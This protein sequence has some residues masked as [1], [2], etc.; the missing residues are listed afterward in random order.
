MKES[1]PRFSGA[2]FWL[3]MLLRA[4]AHRSAVDLMVR[5]HDQPVQVLHL[6]G[7]TPKDL[8]QEVPN[9]IGGIG[10]P[11]EA[12][13]ANQLFSFSSHGVNYFIVD[14]EVQCAGC[15]SAGENLHPDHSGVLGACWGFL[16]PAC[17]GAEPIHQVTA[18]IKEPTYP[19]VA[20]YLLFHARYNT[21][22][23]WHPEQMNNIDARYG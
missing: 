9:C 15:D 14:L 16:R 4:S 23:G 2:A 8:S 7:E 10:D 12:C 18:G 11:G 3:G 17:N 13:D 6:P 22:S 20:I 1:G 21:T 5:P 19:G